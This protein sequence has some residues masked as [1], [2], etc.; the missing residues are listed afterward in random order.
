MTTLHLWQDEHTV[1][2][3]DCFQH[4]GFELFVNMPPEEHKLFIEFLHQ[5]VLDTDISLHMQT[6]HSISERI[7]ANNFS[8]DNDDDM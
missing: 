2:P 3:F 6:M 5:C 7:H 1:F 4:I 8:M